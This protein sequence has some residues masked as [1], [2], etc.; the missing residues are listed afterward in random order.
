MYTLADLRAVT[1]YATDRGVRLLFEVDGPGHTYSWGKGYPDM[2]PKTC[3]KD[4]PKKCNQCY[5]DVAANPIAQQTYEV[6]EGILSD[7]SASTDAQ[8]LHLGGDEVDYDCWASDSK[9]RSYMSENNLGD[10]YSQLLGV[11][12]DKAVKF[13]QKDLAATPLL[14]EDTFMAGVRACVCVCP[15]LSFPFFFSTL[16][17]F[18]PPYAQVRPPLDTIFDVWTDSS[19]VALVTEAGYRVV[20][21]PADY[22]YMDHTDNVWMKMYGYDP[23]A[24]LTLQQ[25]E[26]VV[27]GEVSM[28]GENFMHLGA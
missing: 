28:W 16:T 1:E 18:P 21:A 13:V 24:G 23:A 10:D 27:G 14:W 3:F 6:L 20:A 19:N 4:M 26:L 5:R 9:I 17:S 12:V 15:P 2:M 11:Y 8:F 7:I 25:Q 22:W